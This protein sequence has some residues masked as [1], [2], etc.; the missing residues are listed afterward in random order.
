MPG[1][2]QSRPRQGV[3]DSVPG[4]FPTSYPLLLSPLLTNSVLEGRMVW[5]WMELTYILASSAFFPFKLGFLSQVEVLP[6][7]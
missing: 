2:G 6:F 3:H 7:A 5:L 1:Y 4:S